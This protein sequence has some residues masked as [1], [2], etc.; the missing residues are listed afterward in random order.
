[1]KKEILSEVNRFREIMGLNL[2]SEGKLPTSLINDLV[3][4][5]AK[6]DVDELISAVG[7]GEAAALRK[8]FDDVADAT[9]KDLQ[10]IIRGFRAGSLEGKVED[11][12]VAKLIQ[13]GTDTLRQAAIK[14]YTTGNPKVIADVLVSIE[15]FGKLSKTLSGPDYQKYIANVKGVIDNSVLSPDMKKYLSTEFYT[16]ATSGGLKNAASASQKVFSDLLDDAGSLNADTTRQLNELAKGIKAD[17]GELISAAKSLIKENPNMTVT[18]LKTNLLQQQ[19]ELKKALSKMSDVK[20]AEVKKNYDFIKSFIGDPTKKLSNTK[21]IILSVISLAF[22]TSVAVGGFSLFEYFQVDEDEANAI[23]EKIKSTCGLDDTTL[24]KKV[25]KEGSDEYLNQWYVYVQID[26]SPYPVNEEDGLLKIGKK[27]LTSDKTNF[28]CEL[29]EDFVRPP[30]LPD[31]NQP[32]TFDETKFREYLKGLWK[33]DYK[34]T[35]S[36]TIDGNNVSVDD[37]QKIYRFSFDPDKGTFK[38]TN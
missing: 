25:R 24:E 5:F 30:K 15:D 9:G 29:L 34:D 27:S 13:S 3:S 18:Q 6:N 28:K 16:A 14:S 1:M 2:L 32:N 23:I 26:G 20:K 33:G 35:D 37:G 8:V 17:S 38:Q 22:L 7:T 31:N 19:E 36:V 10:S 12:F 21:K 4:A 11:M